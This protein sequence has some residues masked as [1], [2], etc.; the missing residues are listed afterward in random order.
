MQER[1][2]LESGMMGFGQKIRRCHRLALWSVNRKIAGCL[3][4]RLLRDVSN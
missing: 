2:M 3:T 4:C 1:G